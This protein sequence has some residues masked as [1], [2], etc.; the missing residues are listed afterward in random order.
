MKK[1]SL[2]PY[3]GYA[4]ISFSKKEYEKDHKK[5]FN[6]EDVL[7]IAQRGRFSG[8]CGPDGMWTYLI[9]GKSPPDI[10]HEVCH[11]VL[12]VFKRCG[13][14]PTEGNSEPFCYMVSQ[15]LLDISNM[16]KRGVV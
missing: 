12:E 16:R 8:G 4:Y 1:L 15:I 5:L 6:H 2:R 9:Y 14:D 10:A 3:S 13:I 11:V 7:T